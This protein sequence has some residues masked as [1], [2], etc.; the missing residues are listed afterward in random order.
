MENVNLRVNPGTLFQVSRV[1]P[2]DTRLQLLGRAPGG[3]WLK[4]VNDEGID[5]WVSVN[6]VKGGF[7]GPPPPVVEPIDVLRVSGLVVTELGTP[8]SGIGFSISQGARNTV[9]TT[10]EN[11]IFYAYLPPN[12]TG[13][14]SVEYMSI[15]C[16]SNTMDANCN[17]VGALCGTAEPPKQDVQL[18]QADALRFLWK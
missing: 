6:V 14:W 16:T 2:Q 18:P 17:C 9:A 8:V 12:L 10:D 1:M 11:G 7:D 13:T 5:G 15:A 4:V 3:E